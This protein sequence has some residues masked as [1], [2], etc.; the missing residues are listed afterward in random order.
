MEIIGR[1]VEK[2]ILT[3]CLESKRPEFVAVYGRR[4]VGKTYLVREFLHN[5]LVFSLTGAVKASLRDQLRVFDEAIEEWSGKKQA[6]AT[7][8]LGAFRMVKEHIKSLRHKRKKVIFIDEVPWLATQKSGFISAL[9]HF[10]NSFASTREDI[11]LIICGSA[12]SWIIDNVIE[13]RGGLHN[14]ITR[15]IWIEPFTLAECE[16]YYQYKGVDLNRIQITQ[17]YMVFGGIPYYMDY[18]QKGQ[19]PEQIVD[20]LFFAK[21]APLANEF[22]NLYASLF[23]NP[24]RHLAIIEALG[25]KVSGLTQ[26]EL[27]STLKIKPSGAYSKA[28]EELEQCGFIRKAR[29]FTK[30]KNGCMYQLTDFYTLFYLKHIRNTSLPNP[31]YWQSRSQKGALNALS[32]LAFE[33]VCVAHAEE[34]KFKLGISGVHTEISAWRSQETE[35]G[36]QIDLVINRDDGIVNLCEAKFTAKPFTVDS[37]FDQRLFDKRESFREETLTNRA[38]HTVMVSASGLTDKSRRGNIQALVVLDDLFVS[39]SAT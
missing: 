8:W 37:E 26:K 1:K 5:N 38:L 35:S 7:D 23:K 6:P 14:R 20:S 22:S 3:Q 31:K 27:F 32:G 15:Q 34:I 10:W 12:S 19:S 16:L 18:A 33:R 29:Q 21:G 25:K 2:A 39:L 28:L 11:L 24:E 17:L 13:D 30:A 36:A 4:R 9:D